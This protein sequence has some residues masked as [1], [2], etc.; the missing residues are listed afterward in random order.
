L[1]SKDEIKETLNE[2][3]GKKNYTHVPKK[4]KK[5]KISDEQDETEINTASLVVQQYLSFSVDVIF[6]TFIL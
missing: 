3:K 4:K 2:M 5:I 1:E 6:N